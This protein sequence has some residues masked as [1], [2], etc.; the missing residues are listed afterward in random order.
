M[1]QP[2]FVSRKLKQE[3]KV[4]ECKPTIVNNQ[5]VVYQFECPLCDLRYVGYTLGHL[6]ER[7]EGHKRKASSIYKHCLR[8]H[9]GQ[10][11]MLGNFKVLTKCSGKFDCLVKEMLLIREHKPDLNVQG[12]S[13]KAKVFV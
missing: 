1:I 9:N 12:D 2:V 3:L 4:R 6:H 7:V 5:C 8:K 11:P 10:S 13:I